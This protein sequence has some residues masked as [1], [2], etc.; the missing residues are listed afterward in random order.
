[1]TSLGGTKSRS[2]IVNVTVSWVRQRIV[3]RATGTTGFV[4]GSLLSNQNLNA[5]LF[6]LAGA[7]PTDPVS[8]FIQVRN[9]ASIARTFSIDYMRQTITGMTR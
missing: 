3:R 1:M 5:I 8:P 4:T 6:N 9:S 2:A 7:W